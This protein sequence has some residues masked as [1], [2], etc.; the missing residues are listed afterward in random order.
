MTATSSPST[1]ATTTA[2]TTT[3]AYGAED[4]STSTGHLRRWIDELDNLER[5]LSMQEQLLTDG[6]PIDEAETARAIFRPP[7][8]LSVLPA[9]LVPWATTLADR[10]DDLLRRARRLVAD[11]PPPVRAPTSNHVDVVAVGFDARA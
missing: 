9:E 3:M 10:N 1:T 11:A 4:D 5:L 8:G 2:T 7:S 6:G